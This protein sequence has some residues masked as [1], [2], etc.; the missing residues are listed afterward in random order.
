MTKPYKII[1]K[2]NFKYHNINIFEKNRIY[3][4]Y[5][6]GNM[7]TTLIMNTPNMPGKTDKEKIATALYTCVWR[8]NTTSFNDYFYNI[9]EYRKLK[10]LQL[11]GIHI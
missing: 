9:K 6:C 11:N 3:Y 10:L 4:A 7:I 8:L 5:D 1:C 2:E